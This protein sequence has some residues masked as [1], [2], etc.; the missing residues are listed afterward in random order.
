MLFNSTTTIWSDQPFYY[1]LKVSSIKYCCLG[2][3]RK[4]YIRLITKKCNSIKQTEPV[5]YGLRWI[6][7]SWVSVGHVDFMFLCQFHRR[8][9]AN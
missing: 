8:W 1:P 7:Q 9:E 2:V 5:E 4:E 3:L 6:R